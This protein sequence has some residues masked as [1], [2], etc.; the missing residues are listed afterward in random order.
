[1]GQTEVEALQDFIKRFGET[2]NA[3]TNWQEEDFEW[4]DPREF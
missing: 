1:M 2:L 3:R 4:S